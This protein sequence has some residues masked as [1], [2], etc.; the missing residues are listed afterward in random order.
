MTIKLKNYRTN[1]IFMKGLFITATDTGVGKTIIGAALAST[2]RRS[3]VDVGVMKPFACADKVFSRKY[4]SEDVALLAKAA[5]VTDPDEQINPFFYPIPTAPFVASKLNFKNK[6]NISY[7]LKLYHKL[8][9]KHDFMIVEGIGG[10]MVPL[11]K[12]KY[13]ANFAKSLG[14]STIIVSSLKLGTINHTLLTIKVCK[15]FGLNPIGI[16][17]NGIE[18]NDSLVKDKVVEAI[19]ELSDVKILGVIPF[20]KTPKLSKMRLAIERNLDINEI[21]LT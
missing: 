21:L 15:G 14:L 12:K 20:L 13:I 6:V 5:Q 17:I 19:E 2:I 16:I 11:T 1:N 7:A 18:E 4:K 9:A 10:V 3:G 8:C